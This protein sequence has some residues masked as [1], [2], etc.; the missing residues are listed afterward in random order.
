VSYAHHPNAAFSN[1][2][3]PK[4]EQNEWLVEIEKQENGSLHFYTVPVGQQVII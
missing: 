1:Y 2:M 4:S 3:I